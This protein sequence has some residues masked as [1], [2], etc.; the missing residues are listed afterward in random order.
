MK[1]THNQDTSETSDSIPLIDEVSPALTRI[2]S[3]SLLF[4]IKTDIF[5]LDSM[6]FSHGGKVVQSNNV[7]FASATD[8]TNVL[9]RRP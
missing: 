3:S 8:R 1:Q 4:Q 7:H 9:I 5:G 2:P 6:D